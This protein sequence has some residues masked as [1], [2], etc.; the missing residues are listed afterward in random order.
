VSASSEEVIN[1]I[2][3]TRK[4]NDFNKKVLSSYFG[5]VSL[6]DL[7]GE[8]CCSQDFD[9]TNGMIDCSVGGYH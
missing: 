2:T 1:S 8:C 5:P 3:N 6:L 7:G 9:P 4:Q